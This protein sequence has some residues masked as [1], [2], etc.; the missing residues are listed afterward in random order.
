MM[1]AFFVC[2]FLLAAGHTL[3]QAVPVAICDI[4]AH[5]STYDGRVIQ[6][7]GTVVSGFDEFVIKDRS[8]GQPIDGIWLSYPEGT[9]AK[10]GPSAMLTLQLAANSPAKPVASTRPP[11][12]LDRNKEFK[13]FDDALAAQ[14]K[15]QGLCLGCPRYAVS[16]TLTGRIDAVDAPAL[17]R[18]GGKFSLL[19]GF[20]NMNRYPARLVLQSV[21]NVSETEI[22]Y[23]KPAAATGPGIPLGLSADQVARAAAAFG[24]DAGD[25]GLVV[26]FGVPNSLRKDEDTDAKHESPDGL[27]I[28]VTIA[29]ERLK[30]GLSEGMAH[31]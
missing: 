8:C 21:S 10:A 15:T 26:N 12:I 27:L 25:I 16:A 5:P 14:P 3:A 22:D 13:R 24:T 1:R 18:R 4:L 6:V 17:A 2:F 23:S 29:A 20:G 30:G 19:R 11:V 28:F 31:L 7:S 9:K